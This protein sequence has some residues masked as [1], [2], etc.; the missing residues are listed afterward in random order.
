MTSTLILY[1]MISVSSAGGG[2][3]V[4]VAYILIRYQKALQL[5]YAAWV[6]LATC[7]VMLALAI[8][9]GT[10]DSCSDKNLATRA[11]VVWI[12][13]IIQGFFIGFGVFRKKMLPCAI[14]L[15]SLVVSVNDWSAFLCVCACGDAWEVSGM[16]WKVYRYGYVR[17]NPLTCHVLSSYVRF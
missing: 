12:W 13:I 10:K 11:N 2:L 5:K 8:V 3:A 7:M 14:V 9:A 17:L 16:F 4:L 15:L 6:T 1:S